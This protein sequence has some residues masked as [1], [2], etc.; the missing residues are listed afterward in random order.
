MGGPK[1]KIDLGGNVRPLTISGFLVPERTS[2][3]DEFVRYDWDDTNQRFGVANSLMAEYY[4]EIFSSELG[5]Q[6]ECTKKIPHSAADLMARALPFMSFAT[7]IDN[8]L[9]D[10]E[11]EGSK[12]PLSQTTTKLKS[13]LSNDALPFEDHF[14]D[15]LAA[16][17]SKLGYT[18]SRPLNQTIGK[19]DVVVTYDGSKTCALEAIIATRSPVSYCSSPF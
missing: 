12:A 15:A 16:V 5:Y 10:K 7:V 17:L 8:A 3:G 11:G 14:N 18:V 4:G 6:R 13:P 9:P 2:N 19:T 1:K